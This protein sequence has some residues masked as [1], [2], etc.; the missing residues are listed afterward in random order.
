MA[1]SSAHARSRYACRSSAD[2]QSWAA[3]NTVIRCSSA[4]FMWGPPRSYLQCPVRGRSAPTFPKFVAASGSAGVEGIGQPGPGECPEPVGRPWG[5]PEGG[6][7]LVQR[8]AGEKLELDQLGGLRVG[9]GE[10]V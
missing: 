3:E 2:P 5:E 9:A 10:A 7:G 4:S 6:G 1:G 8:E